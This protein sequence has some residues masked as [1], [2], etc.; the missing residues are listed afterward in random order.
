MD[1]P[2][3]N[4]GRLKQRIEEKLQGFHFDVQIEVIRNVDGTLES[5]E[6]VITSDAIIL[7]KCI[8]WI[9]LN[10]RVIEEML[11]GYPYIDC[12]CP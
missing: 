3:S 1:A 10:A 8:S 12:C 7:D 2:V 9:N 6:N 5:L 4:S 11:G